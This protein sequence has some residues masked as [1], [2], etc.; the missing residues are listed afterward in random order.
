MIASTKAVQRRRRS[1]SSSRDQPVGLESST[2]RPASRLTTGR[3][4][5]RSSVVC[6]RLNSRHG[7]R[8]APALQPAH[9]AR[10]ARAG[11][12]GEVRGRAR[13]RRSARAGWARRPRS[14]SPR[15]ASAR[16][17][18]CDA[19]HVDLTN[20]QRQI[21]YATAGRRRSRRSTRR[22]SALAAINP[23]VRIERVARA[24]RRRASSRRWSRAADVVLDCCDNFATRHAVNRAC[25]A[26]RQAA[27]LG[28]R[29]PLRRPDRGVRHARSRH[30]RATTA[31]SAKARSSRRRAARRWACSRRWS[32][33]S[34]RRR[35]PKR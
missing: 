1:R 17:T 26:A 22:R 5:R 31:C 12:A 32:A 19:D 2:Q 20:L 15:P 30:R 27:G 23:D 21:L 9:P 24:R 14:S 25:V 6:L 11:G 8:A 18:L 13:A 4:V 35:R 10:R 28:R 3:R 7:R 29:D 34:A 33:S 16:I